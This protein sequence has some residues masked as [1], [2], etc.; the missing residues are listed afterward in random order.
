MVLSDTMT[1]VSSKVQTQPDG[2]KGVAEGKGVAAMR[3]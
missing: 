1:Q 2:G 3:A